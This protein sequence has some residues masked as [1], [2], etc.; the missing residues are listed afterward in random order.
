M[1]HMHQ[2]KSRTDHQYSYL[3]F[4]ALVLVLIYLLVLV[5]KQL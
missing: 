3:A 1:E 2:V 4:T 5:I